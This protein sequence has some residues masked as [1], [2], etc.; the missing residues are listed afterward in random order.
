[1]FKNAASFK[2]NFFSLGPFSF[3]QYLN[4]STLKDSLEGQFS[5]RHKV[6]PQ[7]LPLSTQNLV[8]IKS[9]VIFHFN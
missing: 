7:K 1:M 3:N 2:R 8:C 5:R 4:S 6:C 9:L